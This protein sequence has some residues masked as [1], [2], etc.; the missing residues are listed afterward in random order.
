MEGLYDILFFFLDLWPL[1]VTALVVVG[2]WRWWLRFRNRKFI[3]SIKW[4]LLEIRIPKDIAKSPLAMELALANALSQTGGVGTWYHKYWLGNLTNWF[5]LEIVSLGGDVRF[6]VRTNE[7]FKMIVENQIYAQY[8]QAEITEVD[9]YVLPIM[10]KMQKEPW[11]VFGSNFILTKEDPYPIKTYVDYNLD[12]APEKLKQEQI[13]DPITPTIELLGSLKPTENIWFQILVRPALKRYKKPD[14]WFQKGDW[15]DQGRDL[16]KKMKK[17]LVPGEDAIKQLTQ[18]EKDI[19]TALE[20]NISKQGFD[21]G[22]RAMYLTPKDSFDPNR[23]A[24]MLG[25]FKQYST[26]HLNGFRPTK[27]TGFD[28]PWQDP[29]GRRARALKEEMFDAYIRRS[30]FYEPHK[31]EPFVLNSEELATIY[32]FPGAVSET[33]QLKRIESTK[34][35]P[36]INLPL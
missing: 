32:H 19:I 30:Y 12:Q 7:K 33:P 13:I 35:E 11:S 24:A 28:Y 8:P 10:A 25:A 18:Y 31:H 14:T 9:D 15:K 2:A 4:S 22:I 26:Q 23:I 20:R 3:E 29:T 36:P 21:V 27:V 5:S 16:I 17:D 34:S 1:W 6:F